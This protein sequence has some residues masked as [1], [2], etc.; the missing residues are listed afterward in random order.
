[1]KPTR[2]RL[3][4]LMSY[5]PETGIFVWLSPPK[6]NP[7][8]I[9]TR[10]GAIRV[11]DASRPPYRWIRVDGGRYK[12]ANLAWLCMHGEWPPRDI[13]HRDGNSL[14]DAATNHRLCSNPENQANR[15]KNRGKA[16]P[17][18][19][20]ANGNGYTARISFA[21]KQITIGTFHDPGEAAAAYIQKAREL[22][23]E[24]ARQSL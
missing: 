23:G 21:K 12:A 7:Y 9:G 2:E 20:R 3:L 22:Y 19:V 6:H 8:L 11:G 1:M 10:A 5:D 24:F 14:N 16:L 15:R 4:I 18:G 17:K 13:D